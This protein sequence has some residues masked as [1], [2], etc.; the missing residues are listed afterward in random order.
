MLDR[1]EAW[2]SP[3]FMSANKPEGPANRKS[4]GVYD[5]PANADRYRNA[6][7]W[8]WVIAALASVVSI[9]YFVSG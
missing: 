5:R 4:V 6:R 3:F 7:L 1:G 2:A 8:I 9:Y